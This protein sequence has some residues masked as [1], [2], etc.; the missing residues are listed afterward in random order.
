MNWFLKVASPE[1]Y[2][3]SLGAPSESIQWIMSQPNPQFYI[4]EFRKNPGVDLTALQPPQKRQFEPTRWEL[5]QVTQY[6][7][8]DSRHKWLLVQLRKMRTTTTPFRDMQGI[9]QYDYVMGGGEIQRKMREIDD[10]Y[11]AN[12]ALEEPGT[13]DLSSYSWDQA[14]AA[15]DEWHAASAGKGSG[16]IYEPLNPEYVVFSP[17]EWN[18]W[19]IQKV[20]SENDLLVEGNR[21][22]H[23]VG[24]YCPQVDSGATE[25][26]SLRDPKNEPHVTVELS[27]EYNEINQI[28][29]NS[30]TEPDEE[31]KVYL[32]QWLKS[33]QKERPGLKL[34][35]EDMF[36]FDGLRYVNNDKIDEEIKKIV[37]TGN[38]YGLTLPLDQL[39]IENVYDAVM[40]ELEGGN[41]RD[42]DTRN[43]SYI[44]PVI[45]KVAWDADKFR[46]MRLG[47]I[48]GT[49][50]FPTHKD[51]APDE[52]LKIFKRKSGN[53]GV[54]WLWAKIQKDD[55]QFFS[56][57]DFMESYLKQEDYATEEEYESAREQEEGEAMD[58]VRSDSLPYALND[59]I[60]K[61][62]VKLA[63]EDPFLPEHAQFQEQEAKTASKT[64]R[65]VFAD[66]QKVAMFVYGE[67][68]TVIAYQSSIFL[69][70]THKQDVDDPIVRQMA[71]FLGTET[72]DLVSNYRDT[73]EYISSLRDSRP[74]ILQGHVD[75]NT[76]TLQADNFQH[77]TGSR[78]LQNVMTTLGITNVEYQNAE[79]VYRNLSDWQVTGNLPE[80]LFHGTT[81]QYADRILRFGLQPGESTTNYPGAGP[82]GSIDHDEIVFL[83]EDIDRASYHAINSTQE[84]KGF[85]VVFRFKIPD[86][87]L[88]VSDYDAEVM[89]D[90]N[91]EGNIYNNTYKAPKKD[92]D[93]RIKEEPFDFSKKVGVFGYRG[94]IPAN[95]IVDIM[96]RPEGGDYDQ[97]SDEQWISV[98]ADQLQAALEFEDPT[99]YGYEPEEDEDQYEKTYA[100]SNWFIKIASVEL[101][102]HGTSDTLAPK[103]LS[104][105]LVPGRGLVWDEERAK[106]DSHSK[107]SYGGIYLTNN[108]MTAWGAARTATEQFGGDR[109]MTISQVELRSD[110]FLQDE[111]QQNDPRGAFN[112]V[113]GVNANDY[114]YMQW[115]AN[116][117]YNLEQITEKYLD[118]ISSTQYPYPKAG[119]PTPGFEDPRQREVLKPYV[120]E[121][122]KA[123]VMREIAIAVEQENKSQFPSLKYQYPQFFDM[124]LSEAEASYR[125]AAIALMKKT[126]F[127]TNNIKNFMHNVRAM[128]PISFRGRNKVVL[129]AKIHESTYD[130]EARQR[131]YIDGKY[132]DDV[133]ILYV[134]NQ[135]A[136][137]MLIKDMQTSIGG[138]IRVRDRKRVYLDQPR[139][140]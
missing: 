30:N 128:E 50:S 29:G 129:I 5:N 16:K 136:I 43:A 98:T 124:Q 25:I 63:R 48:E 102:Y 4:N 70:D 22:N 125:Q 32:R 6:H 37:Y 72:K 60:A 54:D 26:Y 116:D 33:F 34:S 130:S 120:T 133:E 64:W 53:E 47:L 135:Q 62:L 100:R 99:M 27:S 40:R 8:D 121:F 82:H 123:A 46:A 38:E 111:D 51:I 67:G 31:Y 11:W 134:S 113:M 90:E 75:E 109:L 41:L 138:G 127:M 139:E 9:L 3:G 107:E 79:D 17:K 1:E 117:F 132:S 74:D 93:P 23:C 19:S 15:S 87:N 77:G 28:M 106:G 21:M 88:L 131:N 65:H 39:D 57:F 49:E 69:I 36:D 119:T 52:Q 55:E 89:Y 76:L 59:E 92:Y 73:W 101:M 42:A 104:E 68:D 81:S 35:A 45:A 94:R 97:Y 7:K 56:H 96:I 126:R 91:F 86:P 61:A 140:S 80:N 114:F 84:Q 112:R 110:S 58:A 14:V 44:G 10:W 2:L 18:G 71:N 24:D 78:L 137:Q 20:V 115:A 13:F 12:F 95:F 83:A 108:F 118:E 105:G 103:I 66:L 122:I 85:P